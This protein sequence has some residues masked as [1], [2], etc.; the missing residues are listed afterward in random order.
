MPGCGEG[1]AALCW[2]SA[3]RG[4]S[5]YNGSLC[6]NSPQGGFLGSSCTPLMK[7]V[8]WGC[9]AFNDLPSMGGRGG[10]QSVS[11]D[12]Q[13]SRIVT[14]FQ[15]LNFPLLPGFGSRLLFWDGSDAAP[16]ELGVHPLFPWGAI[17]STVDQRNIL[18]CPRRG[19]QCSHTPRVQPSWEETGFAIKSHGLC[20]L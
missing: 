2:S 15:G 14:V 3:P 19:C 1:V 6:P 16:L 7:A 5:P 8:G 9:K 17:P 10:P 13:P 20:L 18:G 12:M 4:L 11:L